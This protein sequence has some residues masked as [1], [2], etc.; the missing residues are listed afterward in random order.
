[1]FQ[2]TGNR[3][4]CVPEKIAYR[5]I[6]REGDRAFP[7]DSYAKTAKFKPGETENNV[8]LGLSKASYS[9]IEGGPDRYEQLLVT[10]KVP[11]DASMVKKGNEVKVSKAVVRS[12]ETLS[13]ADVFLPEVLST[14]MRPP[15]ILE[16][17]TF[18]QLFQATDSGRVDRANTQVRGPALEVE[19]VQDSNYYYFNMKSFPSTTGLRHK[20]YIRF[21]KP[22]NA[23]PR[24]YQPLEKQEVIVDCMCPDYKFRFA[25]ANKQRQSGLVGPQ[26]LNKAW[27]RAPRITNPTGRPSLCKHLAACKDYIYG[28]RANYPGEAGT[29]NVLNKLTRYATKRWLDIS[30]AM[31]QGRERERAYRAGVATL[32]RTGERPEPRPV[33]LPTR[34]GETSAGLT[35]S[36]SFLQQL[37]QNAVQ[38]NAEITAAEAQAVAPEPVDVDAAAPVTVPAT[39]PAPA[40]EEPDDEN[41]QNTNENR[42]FNNNN[43]DTMPTLSLIEEVISDEELATPA[44]DGADATELSVALP[45][46]DESPE[47]SPEGSEALSLLRDIRDGIQQL[48]GDNDDLSGLDDPEAAPDM[49]GLEFDAAS[50]GGPADDADADA[51]GDHAEPD[52]DEDADG[53]EPPASEDDE[54]EDEEDD[55]DEFRK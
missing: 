17:L 26:S 48:C 50:E 27:N 25:W 23:S 9:Y 53:N 33:Q 6:V 28:A 24:T 37:E 32:R 2:R 14:P 38:Q 31:A 34:A 41:S 4:Y 3:S 12:V 21:F 13:P 22:R 44:G 40:V 55:E 11:E 5:I 42:V 54:D 45:P 15:V 1:M 20:G 7:L 39:T 47:T 18:H 30:G 29:A 10:Y 52:G 8:M 49:D 43:T 16:R 36:G 46:P 19:S 35:E 51:E